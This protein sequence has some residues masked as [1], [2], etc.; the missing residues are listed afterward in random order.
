MEDASGFKATPTAVVRVA[1]FF[2]TPFP[3]RPVLP[4]PR[5]CGQKLELGPNLLCDLRLPTASLWA[6]SPVS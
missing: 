3:T 4:L 6:C 2:H 1:S 5:C